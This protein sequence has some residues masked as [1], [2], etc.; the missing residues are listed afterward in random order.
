MWKS[1]KCTT[2]ILLH[3]EKGWKQDWKVTFSSWTIVKES[4]SVKNFFVFDSLGVK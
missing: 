2:V 1:R 4:D 3:C